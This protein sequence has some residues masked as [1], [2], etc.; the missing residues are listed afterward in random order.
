M[1]SILADNVSTLPAPLSG[2]PSRNR[3]CLRAQAPMIVSGY[4]RRASDRAGGATRACPTFRRRRLLV[5]FAGDPLGAQPILVVGR[6][7]CRRSA[8]DARVEV[9]QEMVPGLTFLGK[10]AAQITGEAEELVTLQ[11]VEILKQK[12]QLQHVNKPTVISPTLSQRC[13]ME[14]IQTIFVDPHIP[15]PYFLN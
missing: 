7:R 5:Q 10:R 13:K 3:R 12:R 2:N 4:R 11:L 14:K 1:A 9:P 6:S 15:S 8:R